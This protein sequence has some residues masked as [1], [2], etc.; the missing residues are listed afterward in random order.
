MKAAKRRKPEQA[1]WQVGSV[2]DFLALSPSEA[3]YIAMKIDLGDSLKQ[4][5]IKNKLSQVELAKLVKSS[6]SRIAKMETGDP[7]VSIDLLMKSLLA[8]GASRKDL[9]RAISS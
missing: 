6:Q 3:A 1:G 5:R 4:R 7:G 2:D 9:A 8:L